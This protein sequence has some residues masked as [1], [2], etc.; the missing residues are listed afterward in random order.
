ML[1][2]GYSLLHSLGIIKSCALTIRT[3]AGIYERLCGR[4]TEESFDQCI[5]FTGAVDG[6]GITA[7]IVDSLPACSQVFSI[8]S[9]F[10]D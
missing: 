10:F 5:C 7:G 3:L 9:A 1:A 2:L 4:W 6:G 8:P